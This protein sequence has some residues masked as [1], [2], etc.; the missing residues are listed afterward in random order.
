MRVD[1]E[2]RGPS[3]VG[4]FR[5]VSA[6]VPGTA[7]ASQN[8]NKI[9]AGICAILLGALGIHKFILGMT[10]PGLIMILVTVLTC[11]WGGIVMWIIGV[12]EGILYL[13]KSDEEFER[14][15]V[16]GKKEWF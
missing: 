11:G 15:Y 12:I 10:K 16:V 5:D 14:V 13:T 3:A 8:G 9:A 4:V 1:F 6:P 7:L 2:V